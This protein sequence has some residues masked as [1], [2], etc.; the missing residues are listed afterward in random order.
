ML[1]EISTLLGIQIPSYNVTPDNHKRVPPDYNTSAYNLRIFPDKGFGIDVG[2]MGAV[3]SAGGNPY[4]LQ[5]IIHT[6]GGYALHPNYDDNR[7]YIGG[8]YLNSRHVRF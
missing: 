5:D 6:L 7:Y 8:T 4:G 3:K 2:L 1:Y